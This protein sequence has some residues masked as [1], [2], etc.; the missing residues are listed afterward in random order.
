MQVLV[1]MK[2]EGKVIEPQNLKQNR[3]KKRA[4]RRQYY[5][6]LLLFI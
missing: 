5:L 2:Q 6:L 4:K 3:L 1:R